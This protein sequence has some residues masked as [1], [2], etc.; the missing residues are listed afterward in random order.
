[1]TMTVEYHDNID[2]DSS[3][4][5]NKQPS[6]SPYSRVSRLSRRLFPFLTLGAILIL[7]IALGASYSKMASRLW[8][9]EQGVSNMSQSLSSLQQLAADAAKDMDRLKFVVA[10]NKEEL[11]S[12]AEALKQL[13]TLDTISRTVASLRCSLDR[14]T[15]NGTT[16]QGSGCCPLDWL[17]LG[18]SCYHFS[19]LLKTWHDA[20]DWCNGHESHLAIILTDE[21][22]NFVHEHMGGH[23]FWLGLTDERGSWEWVNQTPYIM[24]RRRWRPGQPDSWTRHGMGPGDEDCAH[25]HTDGRLNDLH[26]STT[27]QFICQKHA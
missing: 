4:F 18:S 24:N 10:Q 11:H 25:I 2:E 26:C 9:S 27:L 16:P 20:R 19:R 8:S 1:M 17:N 5:W 12:T 14:L 21:E 6:I 13:A 3:S 23:F 15:H 22:W 7:T